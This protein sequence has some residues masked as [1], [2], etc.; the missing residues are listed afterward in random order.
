MADFFVGSDPVYRID[1][2]VSFGKPNS[3]EPLTLALPKRRTAR[4]ER[5]LTGLYERD[6]PTWDTESNFYFEAQ[7]D[8]L[9]SP[10]TSWGRGLG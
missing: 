8:R 9:P 7:E 1:Q 10:S 4:R 5:G 3:Q 6:A 2:G